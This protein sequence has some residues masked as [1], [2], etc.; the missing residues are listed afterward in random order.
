MTYVQNFYHLH[1]GT[2]ARLFHFLYNKNYLKPQCIV[3]INCCASY[4]AYRPVNMRLTTS[5]SVSFTINRVCRCCFKLLR[6]KFFI[7]T[8]TPSSVAKQR[9]HNGSYLTSVTCSRFRLIKVTNYIIKNQ[10]MFK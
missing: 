2:G 9:I 8:V 10:L 7:A 5:S 6:I 3:V 4:H 1:T